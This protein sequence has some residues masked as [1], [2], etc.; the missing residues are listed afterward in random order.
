MIVHHPARRVQDQAVRVVL[1][2]SLCGLAQ[3]AAGNDD[4]P[5]ARVRSTDA[6]LAALIDRASAHSA[7][8][9]RLLAS[10]ERSHGIVY[11]EAGTCT[12]GVRACLKIWMETVGSNRFLRIAIDTKKIGSDAERMG[13]MGHELQHAVE[14]LSESGV[15]D[16]LSLYNF[17]SRLAPAGD[18]RFET[19]AALHAGDD[20]QNELQAH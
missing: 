9:R 13:L 2:A 10:I 20:V 16:S 14:A 4:P 8:F 5:I 3:S 1:I 12:H 18:G 6:S 11:L 7:T 15:T 19:T 17:F